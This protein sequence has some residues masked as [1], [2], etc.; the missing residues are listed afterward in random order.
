LVYC[1]ND[2]C[3]SPMAE[4]LIQSEII[5]RSINTILLVKKI[6][7][8]YHPGFP[9]SFGRCVEAIYGYKRLVSIVEEL[10]VEPYSSENEEHEKKLMA[11][12][13]NLMPEVKL[14]ARI[15]KQWQEIGFQGDD[16]ATDFRGMG[17]LGLLN[18]LYFARE[19]P[20]TARHLVSHSQHPKYGYTFAVVGI[21]ITHMAW[22]LLREGHA[23]SHFYNL[24]RSGQKG[25]PSLEQFHQFYCYLFYEFDAFWM[26]AKPHNLMEFNIVQEKFERSIKKV[27]ESQQCLFKLNMSVENV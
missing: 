26:E 20:G 1:L 22:R 6:N 24:L 8:K 2:L 7:P 27:T 15:T 19:Y 21:N 18:L 3:N 25:Y 16:P 5:D 17:L 10:R 12:W 9:T 13:H 14:E 11:L 4:S 23:K